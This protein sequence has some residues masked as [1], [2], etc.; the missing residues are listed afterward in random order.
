MTQ[1]MSRTAAPAQSSQ[2]EEPL[3]LMPPGPGRSPSAV[4]TS[5]EA[6]PAPSLSSSLARVAQLMSLA[7]LGE[8]QPLMPLPSPA[9]TSKV[10]LRGD[11]KS[12]SWRGAFALFTVGWEVLDG[13]AVPSSGGGDKQSPA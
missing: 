13:E 1:L 10:A 11:Q 12:A 9:W 7:A 5:Q 3:R 4:A 8:P 6:G 2:L